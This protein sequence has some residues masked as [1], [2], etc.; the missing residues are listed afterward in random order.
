[1]RDKNVKLLW[2][3]DFEIVKDGLAESQVV[4]FTTE[5]IKERDALLQRQ[6]HLSSL[7]RL[8]E[9]TILEADELAEEIQRTAEEEGKTKTSKI[10]AEAEQQARELAE[11]KQ[12]EILAAANEAAA[13]IRAAAEQEVE[14]LLGQQR[15]RLQAEIKEMAQKLHSQL[16]AQL[17]GLRQQAIDLQAE[18]ESKLSEPADST[19][20]T[21]DKELPPA[22]VPATPEQKEEKASAIVAEAN[23]KHQGDILEQL[24]K[25]WADTEVT[26]HPGEQPL[27]SDSQSVA[28]S[29]QPNPTIEQTDISTI[30]GPALALDQ[31]ESSIT[32]EGEVELEIL[33]P[34]NPRQ[35]IGIQEYLEGWPGVGIKELRPNNGA[36]SI[37][38]IIDKPIQLVNILRELPDV[39]EVSTSKAGDAETLGDLR[40][41]TITLC[42]NNPS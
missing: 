2:G 3:R 40:K 21:S 41:I 7:T 29:Q 13:A 9:K 22:S 17:E 20:L 32:Y 26:A 4:G 1:M 27:T 14:L 16:V 39:E 35:L 12:S 6:E 42:R 38:V 36:Y 11:Q 24:Q 33:P 19:T 31:G 34:I 37:I 28:P 8:A 10:L 18:W 15:Q 23:S 25:A 30:E 5:L